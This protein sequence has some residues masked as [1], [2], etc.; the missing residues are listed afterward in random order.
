MTATV[1]VIAIVLEKHNV[2]AIVTVI[3]TVTVIVIILWLCLFY[4]R[5]H[6]SLWL[7]VCAPVYNVIAHFDTTT[8]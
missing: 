1:I 6:K 8:Y 4:M 5:L 7:L 2:T 3:A